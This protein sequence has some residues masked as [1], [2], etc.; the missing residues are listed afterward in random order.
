VLRYLA[1]EFAHTRMRGG[2]GEVRAEVGASRVYAAHVALEGSN[3]G[4][5]AYIET[6]HCA[7]QGQ[8]RTFSTLNPKP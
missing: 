4:R 8:R 3:T 7:T 5:R 1:L 6:S 2:S